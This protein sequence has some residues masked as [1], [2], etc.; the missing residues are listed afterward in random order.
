M[1]ATHETD[2]I[3]EY[4]EGSVRKWLSMQAVNPRPGIVAVIVNDVTEELRMRNALS[5]ERGNV[6]Y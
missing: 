4:A 1:A 2:T 5:L 6:S 3:E